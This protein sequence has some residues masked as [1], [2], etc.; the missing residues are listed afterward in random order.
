LRLAEAIG[1]RDTQAALERKAF[2]RARRRTHAAS[3]GAVGL[4]NDQ[5]NF[6][7]GFEQAGERPC[8]EFWSAGED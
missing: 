8:G 1:L 6:V 4:G 3:G 2:H 7:A 5:R